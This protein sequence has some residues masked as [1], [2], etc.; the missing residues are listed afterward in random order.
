[1]SFAPDNARPWHDIVAFYSS[2]LDQPWASAMSRLVDRLQQG[3]FVEAGLHGLTSMHELLLGPASDVLNN[4][5]L[6]VS[7]TT[8]DVRLTYEDGSKPAWSV[9]VEFDE[10]VERVER[11][12]V[13]RAR[14]FRDR[15]NRPILD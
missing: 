13:K 1:M 3:G 12:L 8:D 15:D 11:V 4:P 5:L 14:W 6:R 7:P 10:L 2:F 9:V